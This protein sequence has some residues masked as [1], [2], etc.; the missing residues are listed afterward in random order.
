MGFHNFLA[1]IVEW[2]FLDYWLLVSDVRHADVTLVASWILCGL[3]CN[4]SNRIVFSLKIRNL[5]T[6]DFCLNRYCT[7]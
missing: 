6:F 4:L 5:Q 2:L 7:E 1:S 3:Y